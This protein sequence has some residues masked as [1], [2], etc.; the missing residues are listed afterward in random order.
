MRRM[1]GHCGRRG[2][3]HGQAR[4]GRA[5]GEAV[6]DGRLLVQHGHGG[7]RNIVQD[8]IRITRRAGERGRIQ[9]VPPGVAT[10]S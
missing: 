10:S 3:V 7:E 4:A 6:R 5:H 2:D 9:R 8:G 1:D